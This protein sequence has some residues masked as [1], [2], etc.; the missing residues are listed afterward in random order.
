M[1]CEP[2]KRNFVGTAAEVSMLSS[3]VQLLNGYDRS[4][5]RAANTE[6]KHKYG[7]LSK[8]LDFLTHSAFRLVFLSIDVKIAIDGTNFGTTLALGNFPETDFL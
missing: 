6:L 7:K 4:G 1:D 8:T 3:K 5:L 2:A